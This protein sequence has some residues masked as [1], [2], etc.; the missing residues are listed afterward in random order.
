MNS[1][2]LTTSVPWRT[3]SRY[4]AAVRLVRRPLTQAI[5]AAAAARLLADARTRLPQV[6][7]H[8]PADAH[9]A[10][11]YANITGTCAGILAIWLAARDHG[12]TLDAYTRMLDQGTR[13]SLAAVPGP[14]RRLVGRQ[15]FSGVALRWLHRNAGRAMAGFRH[16]MLPG[17][18]GRS[19]SMNYV[20]CPVRGLCAAVGAPE[21]AP[22]ICELDRAQSEAFGWGL[23]RTGSLSQGAGHCDFRFVRGGPTQITPPGGGAPAPDDAYSPRKDGEA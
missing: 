5:G 21:L 23:V 19:F 11:I 8:L 15:L 14:V 9:R 10:G 2:S 17:A 22:W 3:R 12:I 1:T 13:A 6:A 7:A 16:E 20:A 18:D 4:A